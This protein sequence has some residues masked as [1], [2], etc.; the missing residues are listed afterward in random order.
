[1]ACVDPRRGVVRAQERLA[2]AVGRPTSSC[3]RSTRH[4]VRC[5]SPTR[6]GLGSHHPTPG[7]L[8][9][10]SRIR[11]ATRSLAAAPVTTSPGR[12]TWELVDPWTRRGGS[13]PWPRRCDSRRSSPTCTG[14]PTGCRSRVLGD[15]GDA[16][17]VAQE[18]LARTHV[19]WARLCD[20]P[21]GGIVP[22]GHQPRHRPAPTAGAGTTESRSEPVAW[23]RRTLSERIDL[24]R[25]LRRPVAAPTPSRRAAV[26]GGLA[27]A[28]G[29]RRSSVARRAR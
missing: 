13:G 11:S 23:S 21:E 9:L 1:M 29:G 18:A 7:V 19:R 27:R 26:P 5:S 6:N 28:R 10:R 25:A 12:R 20:R 8:R 4:P 15:R 2:D 16:E 24:A 3:W 17:D 14:S 22:G